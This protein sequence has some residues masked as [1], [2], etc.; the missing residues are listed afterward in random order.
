MYQCIP[1]D[2]A[3]VLWERIRY[4]PL[5]VLSIIFSH[6]TTL[7]L[8]KLYLILGLHATSIQVSVYDLDYRHAGRSKV[9][10]TGLDPGILGWHRWKRGDIPPVISLK[11]VATSCPQF[12]GTAS[13]IWYFVYFFKLSSCFE[14][15]LL[16]LVQSLI[17]ETWVHSMTLEA[18]WNCGTLFCDW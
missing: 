8:W 18:L 7:K 13:S 14:R 5:I 2:L 12:L 9:R 16:V 1:C 10:L 17:C 3:V 15:Q 11:I 4:K 6:Q